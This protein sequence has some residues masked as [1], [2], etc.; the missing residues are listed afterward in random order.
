MTRAVPGREPDAPAQSSRGLAAAPVS[1]TSIRQAMISIRTLPL[2]LLLLVPA[3]AQK[4]TFEWQ[5]RA[6]SIDYGSVPVGK[7]SLAELPVGQSWRLGANQATVWRLSMPVIVADGVVAP[8]E[9]E[10]AMHRTGA[11]KC[12]IVANGSGKALGGSD[13]RIDGEV[14]KAKKPGKKLVIDW[15]KDGAAKLGNQAAKLVVQFGESEWQGAVTIPGNKTVNLGEWKLAVF[16][17]PTALLEGRDKA[18]VPIAVLSKGDREAWNLVV[19]KDEAKLVP[20]ILNASALA[21]GDADSSTVGKVESGEA[22]APAPREVL[23][24]V[25]AAMTKGELLV[26]VAFGQELLRVSVPEPKP[27]A[28]AGK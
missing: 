5:K 7:H 8:G 13:G 1:V 6:T 25:S 27:K 18:P 15:V 10:I 3:L 20:W 28:K 9:Y 2:P 11:A 24:H 16:S 4:P 14:A 12:S 21:G 19:G 26:E 23:E 22:K 17:L